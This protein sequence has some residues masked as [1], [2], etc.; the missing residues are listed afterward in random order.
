MLRD[1]LRFGFSGRWADRH[2]F[3]NVRLIPKTVFI[4]SEA[5][6]RSTASK[7]F[8]RWLH[9]AGGDEIVALSFLIHILVIRRD[10]HSCVECDLIPILRRARVA[11][12]EAED[13]SI[14]A[15]EIGPKA[16]LL[17]FVFRH[18]GPF[19]SLAVFLLSHV[20]TTVTCC[21]PFVIRCDCEGR[22]LRQGIR[23]ESPPPPTESRIHR[24][25]SER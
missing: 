25:E 16:R 9:Y 3:S 7:R 18:G 21:V 22:L 10:D 17:D 15:I 1:H 12:R 11:V 24:Y 23:Q 5:P 14:I 20:R 6:D 8:W 13:I 2:A 19:A 4:D